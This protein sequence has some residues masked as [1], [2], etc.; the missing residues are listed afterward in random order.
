MPPTTYFQM[1]QQKIHTDKQIWQNVKNG[2]SKS[3][4]YD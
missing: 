1:I 2:L 4:T 3:S